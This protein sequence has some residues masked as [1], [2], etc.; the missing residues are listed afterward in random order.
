[1]ASDV[2][3][4]PVD[5]PSS[6]S[7][8]AHEADETYMGFASTAEVTAFLRDVSDSRPATAEARDALVQR[9]RE[10]MPEVRDDGIH[11][12]LGALA[13]GFKALK[14]PTL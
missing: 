5:E 3:A 7:C 4:E 9:I 13:D 1:V 14:L 11:R 6:P 2:T 12:A 8:F 10:M